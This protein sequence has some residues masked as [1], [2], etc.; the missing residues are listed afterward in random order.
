MLGT[1]RIPAMSLLVLLALGACTHPE[2]APAPD[3]ESASKAALTPMGKQITGAAA[4]PLH[5]LN[6]LKAKIPA[7]LLAAQKAP[8]APPTDANCDGL[9]V[10]IRQLDAALGEDLDM[11]SAPGHRNLLEQ[12]RTLAD[13]AAVGAV[14]HAAEDLI[15]YRSWVRRLT[16]A[17]KYSQ[18]VTSAIKAGIVRRAYLKGLGQAQ[19][20]L[21]PSAP[22]RPLQPAA[23]T[24]HDDTAIAPA[25]R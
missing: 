24:A 14:R 1:M 11:P 2:T 15:P 5:D 20:C 21:A 10:E 23:A 4:T 25:S 12:G 22:L 3:A 9:A 13:D 16:G 18:L 6:L 17:E 19:G 7:A 8:Y